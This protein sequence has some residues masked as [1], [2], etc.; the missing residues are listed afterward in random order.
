MSVPANFFTTYNVVASPADATETVIAILSGVGPLLP[1]LTVKL[2]GVVTILTDADVTAVQLTVRQ[3]SL[4]GNVVGDSWDT[5]VP[6]GAAQLHLTC[7]VETFDN[8]GDF[9]GAVYV[10]TAGCESASGASVVNDL[11]FEARVD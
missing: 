8:P 10:L 11:V 2:R 5:D 3:G 1:D 9:A 6:G 4:A 7:T